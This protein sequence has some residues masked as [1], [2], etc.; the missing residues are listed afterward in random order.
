MADGGKKLLPRDTLQCAFKKLGLAKLPEKDSDMSKDDWR[1]IRVLNGWFSV[2]QGLEN[3]HHE[4]WTRVNRVGN[5]VPRG[6]K[7]DLERAS[8]ILGTQKIWSPEQARTLIDGICDEA[9]A[10]IISRL[11]GDQ[12]TDRFEV[13]FSFE[14]EPAANI[15]ALKTAALAALS[16]WNADQS[17]KINSI[18]N[19]SR[20]TFEQARSTYQKSGLKAD[21]DKVLAA[22]DQLDA[23]QTIERASNERIKAHK[24][25]GI[26]HSHRPPKNRQIEAVLALELIW[27]KWST[28]ENAGQLKPGGVFYDFCSVMLNEIWPEENPKGWID[29]AKD[30]DGRRTEVR[31]FDNFLES[32]EVIGSGDGGPDLN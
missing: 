22:L 10:R 24:H 28:H 30:R 20:R 18:K 25:E 19:P 11:P 17:N 1:L 4:Q 2:Y 15:Q 23:T 13:Y 29:R 31:F 7:D 16:A 32:L 21:R 26:R 3:H 6:I 27:S 12:D 9:A 8:K 5:T 14:D